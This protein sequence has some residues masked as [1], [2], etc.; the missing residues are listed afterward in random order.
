MPAFF[1]SRAGR[2]C[3]SVVVLGATLWILGALLH[4]GDGLVSFMTGFSKYGAD[5]LV[6]ALGIAGA[7]SFIYSVLRIADL[8]KE[9]ELRATAQAKADWTATHDHLTK[10]PNRYAFERKILSRPIVD[11][12][13]EIDEWARNVTIFSVDLDGF[14]KVNDLVGH[15]GGDVL[16]IEV[17]KRICALGNA[18]CVYRFG[19]DEFIIIAFGLTA[20]REERFARLLIQ[21]VTRPIHIDG[22]GVEVGASVGYDRWADGSEPLEDAAHRA[23][24]AMYE[25]KS[26]GPNHYLVFEASMQDKVAE[27]AALETRLR[28]AISK[29]AIKP[30]YQPLIDLKTGQ[31]CGFEALAR[32]IGE[33]G[34][35]IPPPVFIDIAEE[36]GMI[37]ALFEDLLA[38]ACSDAL[39]WPEH[40]MLSFNV[41]PVQM[42]DRLLTSRILK[43]LSAS[44]LPPQRLEIEITENALIQDPA[45][46]AIVLEELHAAGIQIALDDFG[47]GYS[48]LAQLARYRFDKIKIDKSFTATC[49]EDERQEKI[50]RAMLGLGRSLN[51]KT[52]AEGVE[53]HGQ[54]AFL[55]QLGCDIGQGYLFGKAMP[56][57]EASA[58]ISDRSA[59]LASTA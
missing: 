5:K 33:D 9:M 41:S 48:S 20:Q 44:R 39:A 50:V 24:L 45:V 11:D 31:L 2:Q 1:Q 51:I 57:A 25:A 55:L 35:N 4:L 15:K 34:V 12:E 28:A 49:R 7:M 18:D 36:T 42:E 30:F 47:T 3:V 6:L 10:L 52:T 43:V 13:A 32:W 19:G 37:T 46:A 14:K 26:R 58:F 56:A 40:V 21:A 22:F 59:N 16:L 38:Q 8:R 27:R 54:L 53:D 17:A 23:D 29:K